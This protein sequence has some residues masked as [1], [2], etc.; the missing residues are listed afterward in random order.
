[1]IFFF[2]RPVLMLVSDVSEHESDTTPLATDRCPSVYP[3][4]SLSLMPYV[5]SLK[6]TI[7]DVAICYAEH[8]CHQ[9]KPVLPV[10]HASPILPSS[11][12]STLWVLTL[13]S[14]LFL[15]IIST[16]ASLLIRISFHLPTG[17]QTQSTIVSTQLL[18]QSLAN[19]VNK[20]KK[21]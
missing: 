8:L 13:F 4:L 21:N 1:M 3:S 7:C 15:S 12:S 14:V 11:L 5:Q 20:R 9:R 2:L 10:V 19:G 6:C 16:S 17:I 18:F